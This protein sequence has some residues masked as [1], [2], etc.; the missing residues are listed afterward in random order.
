MKKVLR[1]LLKITLYFVGLIV[2]YILIGTLLS[3]VPINNKVVAIDDVTIYLDNNGVHTDIIVPTRTKRFDWT[4]VV[5]PSDT[6][7]GRERTYLA[8][9][10]GSQDFYLNVPEWKD[11]TSGIAL[12]AISGTGGTALHTT[13]IYE[14]TL[15]AKCRRIS[16]SA[17]QYDALVQ[18][19]L[20]SGKQNEQGIFIRINHKG[21]GELDAFYE[22]KGHYS[23]FFTCNTWANS[24]LKSCGQKCCLW[25]ALMQPIFWKYPQKQSNATSK[26]K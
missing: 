14:P 22:G 4:T 2:V 6:S 3:L 17:V 8:F 24:A 5:P 11:L 16:L 26:I 21:Y 13:Y 25:T 7:S 20:S 1:W 15:T 10:W 23:P 9:G 12:K 18:Y 19:I